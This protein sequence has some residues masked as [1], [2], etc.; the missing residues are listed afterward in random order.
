[1]LSITDTTTLHNVVEEEKQHP[2]AIKMD[3]TRTIYTSTDIELPGE[4]EKPIICDFGDAEFGE[5][6]FKGE[7]MPDLYRAPEIVLG[8][9]WNEKIDIWSFG[10]MVRY[11]HLD[12]WCNSLRRNRLGICWRANTSST[13]G[14]QAGK[15]PVPLI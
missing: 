14:F 9:A 13:T 1:M 3:A 2:S 8:I 6:S 12:L 11:F 10:L 4:P 15:N 5:G 7:V